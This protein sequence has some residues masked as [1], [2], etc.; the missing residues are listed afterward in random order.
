[1]RRLLWYGGALAI[2]T[3]LAVALFAGLGPANK[4]VPVSGATSTFPVHFWI[5]NQSL[6]TGI[7]TLTMTLEVDAT[8]VF[9]QPMDVGTQHNIEIVD[10][11]LASGLHS[12]KG[13]VPFY[14]V[15]KTQEINVDQEL[16]IFVRF[17]YDPLSAHESQHT[18]DIAMDISHEAP[19]IR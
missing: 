18:P 17:W 8:P 6:G 3:A 13:T 14:G 12:V 1:M 19:G 7:N 9:T 15:E 4:E 2:W 10:Q 5:S 16:W 11:N